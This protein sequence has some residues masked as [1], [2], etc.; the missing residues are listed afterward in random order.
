MKNWQNKRIQKE[1]CVYLQNI[2]QEVI[3]LVAG[4]AENF[5]TIWRKYLFTVF[6]LIYVFEDTLH[7]QWLV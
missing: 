1:G 5:P 2:E 6:F 7:K 3:K 4:H